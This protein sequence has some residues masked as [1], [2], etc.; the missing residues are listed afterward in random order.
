MHSGIRDWALDDLIT[1]LEDT[2][3]HLWP[4]LAEGRVSIDRCEVRKGLALF[5]A[6]MYLRNPRVRTEVEQIH[7]QIVKTIRAVSFMSEGGFNA[8]EFEVKGERRILSMDNWR[9]YQAWG[10]NE[11]DRFF[12]YFVRSEGIR[13]AEIFLKKRWAVVIADKETFITTDNPVCLHHETLDRHGVETEGAII[14][15]PLS[16]TRILVMD[17]MHA[18][19]AN[20]CYSLAEGVG[21]SFNALLWSKANRFLITGRA[22]LEVLEEMVSLDTATD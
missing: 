19:P 2:L 14:T 18:E 12:C 20:Q 1:G 5:A 16:P 21:P 11:H 17:D 3:A 6:V 8:I 4:A 22:V 10:K 9:E 7:A 13:L 15:F